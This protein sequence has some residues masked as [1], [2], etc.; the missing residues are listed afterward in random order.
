VLER[1]V[2][3]PPVE[4][5]GRR[6]VTGQRLT[7]A[8]SDLFLGWTETPDHTRQYYVRQL[9][10]FK[11]QGDPM[12]MAFDNLNH[13]GALCAWALARAHARTGDPVELAGYLGSSKSFDRALAA[14]SA[15]YART[16]EADHAALLDAIASGR[17]DA[18]T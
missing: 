15:A 3:D 17:L 5:N 13:Y 8:A 1:Y 6:V 4:H 18:H 9:W 16:N 10:D 14:F 2:G 11:G 12:V 7:Q